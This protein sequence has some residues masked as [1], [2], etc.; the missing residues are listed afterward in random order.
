MNKKLKLAGEKLE[1]GNSDNCHV[2][3]KASTKYGG[4]VD[5]RPPGSWSRA[6]GPSRAK[7]ARTNNWQLRSCGFGSHTWQGDSLFVKSVH[8]GSWLFYFNYLSLIPLI[9]LCRFYGKQ[10]AKMSN[11]PGIVNQGITTVYSFQSAPYVH[12]PGFPSL[13]QC[14]PD[15]FPTVLF[16]KIYLLCMYAHICNNVCN[17]LS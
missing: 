9:C 5:S 15:F 10:L 8:E 1:T 3:S 14:F 17:K 13:P 12:C 11:S 7:W 16:N 6:T 2:L 4:Y